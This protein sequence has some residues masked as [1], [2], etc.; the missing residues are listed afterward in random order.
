MLLAAISHSVRD[1]QH[2]AEE[3]LGKVVELHVVGTETIGDRDAG[4]AGELVHILG[5]AQLVSLVRKR[6]EEVTVRYVP[7]ASTNPRTRC[8]FS[9]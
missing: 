2:L 9:R 7:R 8:G 1:E 6:G 5:G 3:L 4:D